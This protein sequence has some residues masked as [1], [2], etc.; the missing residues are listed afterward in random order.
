MTFISKLR[1]RLGFIPE[2]GVLEKQHADLLSEYNELLAFQQSDELKHYESL[3]TLVNSPAYKQRVETIKSQKFNQTDAFKKQ[4]RFQALRKTPSLKSYFKTI[5][6]TP[7]AVYEK[8]N[9]SSVI[10]EFSELKQYIQSPDFISAKKNKEFKGSEAQRKWDRFKEL[11]KNKEIKTYF[12]FLR[13]AAFSTWQQVQDSSDLQEYNELEAYLQSPEY[14]GIRSF[15]ALSPRKK[16]EQSEEYAQWEEYMSLQKSAAFLWYFKVKDSSKFDEI[17]RWSLTFEDDFEE[18]KLDQEKWLTKYYYGETVLNAPYSLRYD[19][20]FL[21]D[22]DNLSVEA[23]DCVIETREQ[24]INGNAWH[25]KFGFIPK[26]YDFTSGIINTGM[27]FRQQYGKFEAKIKVD[28]SAVSHA[29]WLLGEKASPQLNICNFHKGKQRLGV[30]WGKLIKKQLQKQETS[31]GGAH[32]AKDYYIYSLEWTPGKLIWKINGLEAMQASDKMID[33]PLY[34]A[35]SSGLLTDKV[36]T[37][38]V[39]G[40]MRI[41]WVRC[42]QENM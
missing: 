36:D 17:K 18:K 8:L 31:V 29:F 42:Y 40:F 33:Q 37:S 24:K 2:T 32:Y 15:M 22:G 3:E 23:S 16:L 28:A 5:K 20:H 4:Q 1:L 35:L 21:T 26:T 9:G 10:E 38:Q 19:H 6:S 12:S 34:L 11:K 39:P 27:S 25:H 41:D 7:Y 14:Q 13:S 30:Y